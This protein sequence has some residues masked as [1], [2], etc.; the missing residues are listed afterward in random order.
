M[1]VVVLA[2]VRSC[3]IG[4]KWSNFRITLH[5]TSYNVLYVS[6]VQW[7]ICTMLVLSYLSHLMTFFMH[8]MHCTH[9]P[10]NFKLISK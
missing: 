1:D 5:T 7:K 6:S 10:I 4:W 3:L 9:P 2:Y 8:H